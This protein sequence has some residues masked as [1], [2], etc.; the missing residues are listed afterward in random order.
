MKQAAEHLRQAFPVVISVV[1][2]KLLLFSYVTPFPASESWMVQL[3]L[4]RLSLKNIILLIF[5]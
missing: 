2:V 5:I 3:T 4:I 1:A